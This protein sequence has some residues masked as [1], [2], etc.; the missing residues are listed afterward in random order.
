MGTVVVEEAQQLSH[1][2]GKPIV[3]NVVIKVATPNGSGS[4]SANLILLRAI[5]GMGIP[6]SAKNVF[7]SNIQGLP[8]W[9]V[10]R[11][12]D[13]GWL[14]Q[15]N[16]TGVSV[17][18]N[19][20]TVL[21]DVAEL[22]PGSILVIDDS[23]KGLVS[24]DDL[25][26]YPV[27]FGT[28]V[29]EVCEKTSLRKMVINI[30]YVG[31]VASILGIPIQAVEEATDHQF[32]AKPKAAE[33]NKSAAI[34]GH[35]WAEANLEAQQRYRLAPSTAAKGKILIEGNEST[36]IG[37]MF[38]GATF[39]SWYP[40]TPSSSVCETLG[41]YFK[42][43]RHD[44]ETGKASYAVLQAE[45]ELGAMAMVLGA[46]WVGARAVT[47][48][49]GPGLSLMAELAGLSYFAEIPAVIVDVQR[50]G[51]STGLP[52][53]NSQGDIAK[54]YFLSHGDCKHVVLIPG[55]VRECYEFGGE[56]LELAEKLQTLVI[57]M[58]DL[59]L[60]MNKWMSEPFDPPAKPLDR[61]KVLTAEE[62]EKNGDFGR[63]RDVDGDGVAYRTLPGT[64]HPNAAFF[65]RGTGHNEDAN[66]TE[67][68]VDWK[69]NI[70]RLKRK[71]DTAREMVPKPI[72]ERTGDGE[73]GLIAY[74]SSDPAVQ[75]ARHI[76]LQQNSLPTDYLRVRALPVNG[77]VEAFIDRYR[78][79]YVIEQNSD[80]QMT[81][82]LR[83][84]Y[85]QHAEK[86][87]SILHYDGIPLDA[88]TV[89][90]HILRLES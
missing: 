26:I 70:D 77:E 47:A 80:G 18:V 68:S 39:L 46:S 9:F 74:G 5:F 21:E 33:L 38:G 55:S 10:I 36:A 4:T 27:P 45:D 20:A 67:N 22:P 79:V 50:M 85:P 13:H 2:S 88:E 12:N 64:D 73:I 3:N 89:V 76:L 53:R 75:E 54:G 56:S 65:T 15:K 34:A 35:T 60:G 82:I 81:M 86:V 8:T 30:I 66:Y 31:V 28:L 87:K 58:S 37:L 6:V 63:Y 43:Y 29:K 62:L 7:P 71:F 51:P 42:R 59:D 25:L 44:P 48:T 40:I 16:E 61:G 57:L 78:A 1:D 32:G 11:V 84:E 90:E 19:P 52:T 83:G 69:N 41:T 72:I 49:S 24:R 14:A 17:A 23:L